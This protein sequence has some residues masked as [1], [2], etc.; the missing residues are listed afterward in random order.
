VFVGY[1]AN[2]VDDVYRLLNPK[3]KSI[4]KSRGVV[5]LN[6]S[7]GAWIKSKNDT[8]ISDDSDCEVD[9]LKDKSETEITFNDAPNYGKNEK[10]ARDLRQTSK[11]NSWFN[12]NQTRL[13]KNSDSGRELILEDAYIALNLIDSLKEPETFEDAY[14]HLNFEERVK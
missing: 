9:N 13:V 7:Y 5:W 2:H 11:L 8:S 14:Y 12:P 1:A 4:I 6:K 10:I 3:T